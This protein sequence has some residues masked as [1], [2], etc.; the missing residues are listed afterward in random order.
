MDSHT[1]SQPWSLKIIL[2]LVDLVLSAAK[3]VNFLFDLILFFSF[4]L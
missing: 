1:D 4:D 2:N 3:E